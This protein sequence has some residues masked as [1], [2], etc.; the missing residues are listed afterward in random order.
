MQRRLVLVHVFHVVADAARVAEFHL[1]FVVLPGALVDEGDLE[2]LVQVGQLAQAA[3]DG[4]AVEAVILGKDGI[5]RHEA[6]Q[7]A[8][9][10]GIAQLLQPAHGLSA[11]PFLFLFVPQGLK[12]HLVMRPVA[13]AVDRHPLGQRVHHRRAHAVQATGIGVVLVAEFAARVQAGIDQFDAADM[14]LRV[15]VHRHAA[16]V[17][18]YRGAAVLM[19]GDDQLGSEAAQ[20]LVNAVVHD[21]PQQVM[22]PAR[23]RGAD[24]HAR[25]HAHRVQPL[26]HLELSGVV[27]VFLRSGLRHAIAPLFHGRNNLLY[28]ILR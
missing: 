18:P 1:L 11:V 17:V 23:A 6:H 3:A 16:A 4:L 8:A 2:P 12:A 13:E 5:V 28:H 27:A 9:L 26:Q 20:G 14:Q 15:L 10:A 19:Q 21:L 22:Q 24:V 25:T 7:R